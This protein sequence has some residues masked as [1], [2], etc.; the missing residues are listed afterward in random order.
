MRSWLTRR[1][2]S[3]AGEALL[4][5]GRGVGQPQRLPVDRVLGLLGLRIFEACGATIADL[6]EEHGHRVLKVRGKAG[7]VTVL[8]KERAA[9]L[10]WS[11]LLAAVRARSST[12][13]KV[14]MRDGSCGTP[15]VGGWTG[16]P[17]PVGSS[18][19]PRA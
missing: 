1:R 17:R 15:P 19:C 8:R 2:T 6:G 10:S 13:P 5:R 3:C 11:P 12:L 4:T 16:T 14:A 18:N 9:R 7:A